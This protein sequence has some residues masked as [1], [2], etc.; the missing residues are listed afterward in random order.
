M[1]GGGKGMRVQGRVQLSCAH[2]DIDRMIIPDDNPNQGYCFVWVGA[3]W[4]HCRGTIILL[5][6]TLYHP[7]SISHNPTNIMEKY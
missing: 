6:H 5:S 7:N 1:V 2:V 3:K 4:R